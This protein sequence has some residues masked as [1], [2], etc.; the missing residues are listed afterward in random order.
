MQSVAIIPSRIRRTAA[1]RA[2]LSVVITASLCA[3]STTVH[4]PALQTSLPAHWRN[5]PS[6]VAAA[7]HDLH[8]W[9]HAFHDARLNA[10]V[11]ASLHSNLDVAQAVERLRAERSLFDHADAP[12]LPSLHLRTDNA[13]DP[14]AGASYFTAGFDAQWELG[15]FGRRLA[16]ERAE[17]GRLGGVEADLQQARVTLVAEVVRN[18][19]DLRRAE[20][21]LRILEGIRD[22]ERRNLHWF[23]ERVKLH[24]AAPADRARVA[25]MLAE[26]NADITTPRHEADAAAQRLALLLGIAEP[27]PDWFKSDALPDLGGLSVRSLPA[28]M[29]R[30]RPG[31]AHAEADV[32][33]A[34]GELG[35]ARARL[36]PNIGIGGSIVWATSTLTHKQPKFNEIGSFGPMIDIP[37]FNWGLREAQVHAGSHR[38][39]ASVLAYRKAV[40]AGVTDVET[41]LNNLA[42][43]RA[44][45]KA[46]RVAV[47]VL[48]TVARQQAER[49]RLGLDNSFELEK[50][51]IATDRARLALVDAQSSRDIAYVAL[52]KALGAAPEPAHPATP[53]RHHGTAH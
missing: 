3:C 49:E 29:L 23:D 35:I 14:D 27:N 28:D 21:S 13:I 50:S 2:W 37:L 15:L 17:S 10:L 51:K 48:A 33:E 12:F 11:T 43:Q 34:A 32:I 39:E 18:W 4:M 20:H 30:S 42:Q 9:W 40:L 22:A 16:V 26:A 44:R 47:R 24:L 36:Y 25:A 38:L 7:P 52:F 19:I 1:A 5:Q 41:A 6:T 45:E 31:I 46:N 8:G 53:T